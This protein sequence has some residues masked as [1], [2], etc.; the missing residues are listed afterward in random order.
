MT[1]TRRSLVLSRPAA[2]WRPCTR[3]ELPPARAWPSSGAHPRIP[4]TK[5]HVVSG[6]VLVS[7]G[8]PDRSDSRDHAFVGGEALPVHA[9]RGQAIGADRVGRIPRRAATS[10]HR[11]RWPQKQSGHDGVGLGQP[12]PADR[13]QLELDAGC[14]LHTDR[15]QIGSKHV[16]RARGETEGGWRRPFAGARAL[17]RAQSEA[18][19]RCDA[20]HAKSGK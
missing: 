19:R 13:S 15:L 11:P 20:R 1:T 9:S 8:R 2:R 4:A 17:L 12:R 16:M 10:R 6:E 3:E 7:E 18:R 5:A 14:S